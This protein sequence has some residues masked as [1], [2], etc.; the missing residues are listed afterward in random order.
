MAKFFDKE[1][2]PFIVNIQMATTLFVPLIILFLYKLLKIN[3]NFNVFLLA[4][5]KI[6]I[7][8]FYNLLIIPI[9]NLFLTSN[10]LTLA[11]LFFYV[12]VIEEK[13]PENHL[14]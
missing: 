8:L 11:L 6:E 7:V 2:L 9:H 14:A 13:S 1:N 10:F 5:L 3:M 4:V 12:Q